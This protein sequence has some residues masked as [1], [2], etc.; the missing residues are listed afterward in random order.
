[1]LSVVRAFDSGWYNIV[2]NPEAERIVVDFRSRRIL[3][4]GFKTNPELADLVLLDFGF[5]VFGGKSYGAN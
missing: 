5:I 3:K 4:N 2:V 1:M